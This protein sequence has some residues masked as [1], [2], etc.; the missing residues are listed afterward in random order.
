M[1]FGRPIGETMESPWGPMGSHVLCRVVLGWVGLYHSVAVL[2]C[3]VL[4][5]AVS[6][7]VVLCC[8]VLCCAVSCCAGCVVLCCV[9]LCSVV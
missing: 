2:C 9:V 5:C 6:C 7:C 4:C 1:D 3:A 8:V